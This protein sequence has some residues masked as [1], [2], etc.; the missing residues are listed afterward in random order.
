[1]A[2]GR[3]PISA[4][5]VVPGLRGVQDVPPAPVGSTQVADDAVSPHLVT[6]DIAGKLFKRIVL[7]AARLE[8]R[9][10]LVLVTW[11]S[12]I[13]RESWPRNRTS[14]DSWAPSFLSSR[15]VLEVHELLLL[16][17]HMAKAVTMMNCAR[18]SWTAVR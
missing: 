14:I 2:L 10:S 3:E 7:L 9:R 12:V 18:E 15:A 6:V 4:D 13:A 8:G 1:M 16:A 11:S 17:T 5:L